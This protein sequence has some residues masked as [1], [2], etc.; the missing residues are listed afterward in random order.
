MNY[1]YKCNQ[2]GI[3]FD[4]ERSIHAEASAPNCPE[5]KVEMVRVYTTPSIQFRGSGFYSTDSK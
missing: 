2:C 4:V 1:P 3:E 5:C